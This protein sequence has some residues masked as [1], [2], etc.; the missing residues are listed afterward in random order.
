MP[1]VMPSNKITSKFMAAKK[2]MSIGGGESM[3]KKKSP[4]D[5]ARKKFSIFG[6]KK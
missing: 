4:I 5:D 1:N 3:E 2:K 6:K